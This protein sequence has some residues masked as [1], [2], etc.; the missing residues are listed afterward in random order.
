MFQ[1]KAIHQD[2]MK[3]CFIFGTRPEIIKLYS[4][5]QA[6]EKRGLDY[7]IIHS[8]QHYSHNMDAIFLEEL[9]IKNIR[10]NLG[11]NGGKHGEMTGK[12]LIELE[13]ILLEEMP[14]VVFVQ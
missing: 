3:I 8:N 9:G 13:K 1:V 11:V 4:T 5:I 10:Y 2:L 14:D 12:M 7:F 6:C